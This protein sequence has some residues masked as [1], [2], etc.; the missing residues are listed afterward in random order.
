MSTERLNRAL[1]HSDWLIIG[2]NR[3]HDRMF[4]DNIRSERM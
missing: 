2:Q 3:I 1:D 4:F